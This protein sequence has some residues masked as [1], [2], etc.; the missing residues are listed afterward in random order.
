[1]LNELLR[2]ARTS[3]SALLQDIFGAVALGV[4]LLGSLYLPALG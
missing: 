4:L 3:P 1:M 2:V